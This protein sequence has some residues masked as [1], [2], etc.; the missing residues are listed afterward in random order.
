M[1]TVFYLLVNDRTK[2]E[3]RTGRRT[4]AVETGGSARATDRAADITVYEVRMSGRM[5]PVYPLAFPC[6]YRTLSVPTVQTP[7]PRN[8]QGT[9][10]SCTD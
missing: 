8:R 10:S 2:R 1:K 3:Y 9:N 6:P 4:D 5:S 7:H